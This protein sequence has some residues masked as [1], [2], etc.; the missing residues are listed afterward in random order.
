MYREREDLDFCHQLRQIPDNQIRE[1]RA[2]TV[3]SRSEPNVAQATKSAKAVVNKWIIVAAT[4]AF[5]TLLASITAQPERVGGGTMGKADQCFNYS[6]GNNWDGRFRLFWVPRA[7]PCRPAMQ[8][9]G[10]D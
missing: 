2:I 7:T 4:I 1:G 8:S 5:G 6:E 3:P 9:Y 10:P